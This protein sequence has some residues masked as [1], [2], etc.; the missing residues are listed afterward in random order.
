[1]HIPDSSSDIMAQ[2]WAHA[3]GYE[4]QRFVFSVTGK[5]IFNQFMDIRNVGARVGKYMLTVY[6]NKATGYRLNPDEGKL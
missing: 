2:I 1:M 4:I 5:N 3:D 6:R